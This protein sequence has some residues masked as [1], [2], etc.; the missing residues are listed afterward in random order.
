M[1]NVCITSIFGEAKWGRYKRGWS[2]FVLVDGMASFMN[3]L[4]LF[5]TKKRTN[6]FYTDPTWPLRILY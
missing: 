5:K 1:C 2:A 4:C 6:A 3:Q